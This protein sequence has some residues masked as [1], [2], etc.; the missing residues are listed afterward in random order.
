MNRGGD[1]ALG[2]RQKEAQRARKQQEKAARRAAKRGQGPAEA[3]I[4]SASD[5]VGALPTVDEAMHALEDRAAAPR[6][7]APIPARLFVG[8]L[9][10]TTNE[11]MLREAFGEYGTVIEVVI[12]HDRNT[13]QPRGF[14]FVT[15]ED[16]KNAGRAIDALNGFELNGRR[17]MVDVATERQR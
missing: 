16:R 4:V 9:G 10:Q 15:M 12:V 11:A 1:Y 7:V 14:G 2:K 3:E 8:G 13:G 6:S 5:V 17:L